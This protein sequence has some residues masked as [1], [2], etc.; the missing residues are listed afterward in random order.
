M[1]AMQFQLEQSQW[2]CHEE[3][4]DKQL[5]QLRALCGYAC[6]A[7]PYY[8]QQFDDAGV[9]PEQIASLDAWRKLP[10]LGARRDIQQ[11]GAQLH[12]GIK[13]H[14]P[15]TTTITSG[16]SGQPVA[17]LSTAVHAAHVQRVTVAVSPLVPARSAPQ[18]GFDPFAGDGRA[19][20]AHSD[21]WGAAPQD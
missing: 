5:A 19:R 2:L 17:T 11:L 9:R 3:L 16:S 20:S 8:R 6:Q 21:N 10:L 4:L 15:I 7:V 14:G 13:E 12:S 18:A 1:L